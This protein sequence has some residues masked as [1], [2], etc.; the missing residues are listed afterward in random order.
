L[1]LRSILEVW[2]VGKEIGKN[3]MTDFEGGGD[4]GTWEVMIGLGRS[5]RQVEAGAFRERVV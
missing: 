2:R 3:E 1:V 5:I 4:D